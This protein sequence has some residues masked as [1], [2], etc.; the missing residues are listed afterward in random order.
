MLVPFC[1]LVLMFSA[2]GLKDLNIIVIN[3]FHRSWI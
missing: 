3:R 1:M 2:D